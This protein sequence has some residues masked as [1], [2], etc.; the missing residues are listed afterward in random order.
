MQ[1]LLVR[2]LTIALTVLPLVLLSDSHCFV[3][4]ANSLR[5]IRGHH[6]QEKAIL[7]ERV[8]LF[9]GKVSFAPP[10]DFAKMTDELI[11][12]KFPEVSV[13]KVAFA[14]ADARVSVF[15][16]FAEERNLRP[17]QLPKF[18]EFMISTLESL[19]PPIR[20]LTKDFVE[21]DGRN[22]IHLEYISRREGNR[23]VHNDLYMTSLDS[24]ILFFNFNS[25]TT[26][27]EKS[28]EALQKSKESIVVKG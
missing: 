23:E 4:S 17:E 5:I 27:Y 3:A 22:W 16:S 21:I 15:V 20:W 24:R 13:P 9:D 25:V 8:S 19:V 12:K 28:K 14:N 18:Q 1:S 6:S 11:E 7:G 2:R 10:A 26:E